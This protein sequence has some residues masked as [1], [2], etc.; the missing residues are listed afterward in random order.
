MQKKKAGTEYCLA[1]IILFLFSNRG[2]N[3]FGD[4]QNRFDLSGVTVCNQC[5]ELF[6]VIINRSRGIQPEDVICRYLKSFTN[7]CKGDEPN[8]A[9]PVFNSADNRGG[10]FRLLCKICLAETLRGPDLTNTRSYCLIELNLIL[11]AN[12]SFKRVTIFYQRSTMKYIHVWLY[13]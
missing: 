8:L 10:E 1:L 4:L 3:L 9:V 7:L 12:T 2:L 11:Q 6:G 13:N 5:S